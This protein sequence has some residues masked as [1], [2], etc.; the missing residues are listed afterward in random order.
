M[1]K[2]ISFQVEDALAEAID[3]LVE[4]GFYSSRSEW[5]KFYFGSGAYF[6]RWESLDNS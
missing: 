1:V 2:M 5:A 3:N 4:K 6:K